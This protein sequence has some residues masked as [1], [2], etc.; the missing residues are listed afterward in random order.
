M[1]DFEPFRMVR[2]VR[3]LAWLVGYKTLVETYTPT[4]R[5]KRSAIHKRDRGGACEPPTLQ[6]TQSHR[7]QN[8]V[9]KTTSI[10]G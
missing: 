9:T 3:A 1:Q 4:Q 6:K 7:Q 5:G 8:A 10:T 2:D